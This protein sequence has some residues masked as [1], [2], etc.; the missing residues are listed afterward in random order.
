MPGAWHS[1]SVLSS[2][3]IKWPPHLMDAAE[4]ITT[5]KATFWL[6]VEP[7]FEPKGI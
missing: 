7:K 6:A 5:C 2:L 3:T 4:V 1:L